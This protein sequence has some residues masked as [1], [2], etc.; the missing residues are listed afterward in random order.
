VRKHLL[1]FVVIAAAAATMFGCAK[2]A[3]EAPSAPGMTRSAEEYS[4]GEKGFAKKTAPVSEPEMAPAPAEDRDSGAT[5]GELSD[6]ARVVAGVPNADAAEIAGEL[7]LIKTGDVSCEIDDID[8]GFDEVY[9]VAAAEK[10]IVVDTSRSTAEEG[11]AYGAVTIKV[12]PAKFDETIKALR[13]IGRLTSETST[14][15]DVTAE[16]VDTQA[17]LDN[18]LAT[19]DR[20]LELLA[21]RT[22]SVQDILEV[23]REIERVTEN[24][25]RFKG[26]MRYLESQIGLSTITVHLE[27]PHGAIP[28]GYNFGKAVKDAFRIA[29]R[30]CIF[31][32]QAAI[33]LTPFV[34][35]LAI[36]LVLIRI[37]VW[38]FQR[39]RRKIKAET[40]AR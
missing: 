8:K 29:L 11:Y 14:S 7:K 36:F 1:Y 26:Q 21:T 37:V 35:L 31:I 16:Y 19:R 12:H 5:G 34:I 3:E 33:I 25:E 20:Y 27:E 32:V 13:K 15:Q 2:K 10:G 6:V 22:G 38:V 30:I 39:R 17:R 18:A 40:A 23:E 4:P 28:T 24:I 9:K